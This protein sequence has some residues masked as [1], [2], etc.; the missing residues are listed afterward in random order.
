MIIYE[1]IYIH[2]WLV[3]SW[4]INFI[5]GTLMV[6][7]QQ[8]MGFL[9]TNDDYMAASLKIEYTPNS[10]GIIS[11]KYIFSPFFTYFRYKNCH[12]EGMVPIQAA[13]PSA[14]ACAWQVIRILVEESWDAKG[15]NILSP[16]LGIYSKGCKNGRV[17][18]LNCFFICFTIF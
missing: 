7:K 13:Y 14:W 10:T 9:G 11:I 12:L 18:L 15:I 16:S 17:V 8:T 3:H 2:I 1:Y 6:H 4:Y 5:N